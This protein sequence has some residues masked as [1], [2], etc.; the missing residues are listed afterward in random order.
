MRR[1]SGH[2][3]QL[4]RLAENVREAIGDFGLT[5]KVGLCGVEKNSKFRI[6]L[7][8]K[9]PAGAGWTMV[10]RIPPLSRFSGAAFELSG[11][12]LFFVGNEA[13]EVTDAVQPRSLLVVAAAWM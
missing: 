6:A 7:L 12:E 8:H 1:A 13:Q 3:P 5:G 2:V 11:G 4:N 10:Y 9:P